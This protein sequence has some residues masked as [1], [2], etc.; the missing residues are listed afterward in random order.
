M[1]TPLASLAE[2]GTRMRACRCRHLGHGPPAAKPPVRVSYGTP[3]LPAAAA[4][5]GHAA[6]HMVPSKCPSNG[7]SKC[8]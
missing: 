8:P 3:P 5:T 2:A 6:L 4:A 7:A 1:H